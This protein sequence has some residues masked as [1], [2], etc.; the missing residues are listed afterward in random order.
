MQDLMEKEQETRSGYRQRESATDFQHQILKGR[1]FCGDCGS[2]MGAMK[3]LQRV[4]SSL[5][6]RMFYQCNYYTRSG[7]ALCLNHYIAQKTLLEKI[8]HAVKLQIQAALEMEVFLKGLKERDC[9]AG[10]AGRAVKGIRQRQAAHTAKLEQLLIDYNE[11][12]IDKGEYTYIKK[13]YDAVTQGLET[14]LKKA[15]EEQAVTD[16]A[17]SMAEKW[18]E[19]IKEFMEK[20]KLDREL[21]ECLIDRV[22]VYADR[23]VEIVFTFRD[24][25]REILAG[26]EKQEETEDVTE[27]GGS[28][29]AGHIC[30]S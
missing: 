4:T 11:G 20:G 16:G 29:R 6:P 30:V 25:Y 9:A 1:V 24:E 10:T 15:E 23:S 21:V 12:V 8:E 13:R 28:Y 3:R 18:I 22:N 7:K 19:K 26:L 2:A 5:P 27:C 14:E 17:V